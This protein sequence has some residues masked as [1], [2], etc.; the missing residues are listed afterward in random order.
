MKKISLI[1]FFASFFL[2]LFADGVQPSGSG[3]YSNPYQVE[4]L[5]NLLWISTNSIS[6]NKYIIQT[7]DIDASETAN[8]NNGSGFS[9]IGSAD[10]LSFPFTGNYNGQSK[11]INNLFI[12]RVLENT[13][14]FGFVYEGVL[15]NIELQNA[16][17][18]GF[19]FVGILAGYSNDSE[20][21]NIEVSGIINGNLEVGA[22]IGKSYG[23]TISDCSS[24]SSVMGGS[25]TGG[26]IGSNSNSEISNC[27]CYGNVT[28]SVYTGG[29]IGENSYSDIEYSYCT[30]NVDG[31]SPV[32]GFIA[33]NFHGD[34]MFCFC[35]G[36]VE[37]FDLT[38]GFIGVSQGAS[39]L[40]QCCSTGDVTGRGSVGGFAGNSTGG[41]SYTNLI[42]NCFSTGEVE[43]DIFVGGFAGIIN[44][45]DVYNCYCKGLVLE[46]EY[47]GGFVAFSPYSDIEN[48][49]WDI[50]TSGQTSSD[51]GTGKTT[52]EMLNVATYTS[53]P[54]IG[55]D[56]PWD[57]VGNP[58]DDTG[59]ED[60]WNIDP[61]END[62]YP[63][64]TSLPLVGIQE[65]E[66]NFSAN[67]PNLIGNYPNP[68][69]PTT[70]FSFSISE[71]S[72]VELV[73]YNIK[74]QRV[75]QLV[76]DRFEKGTHLVNWN[77]INESGDLIASGVYFYKLVV[78]GK[79]QSMKKCLMIK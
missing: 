75:M 50:E 67:K 9:P 3:T 29:F 52:S 41:S 55:L 65:E 20:V 79:H 26:L 15:Q 59:N 47:L 11:S 1:I 21:S 49:F 66:I 58:F 69:N 54:T 64:L 14:F 19:T 4:T 76:N 7:A 51:G 62:G 10:S 73:I 32:G 72:K 60:F 5:D 63:F 35:T 56:D 36:N 31:I 74:G 37:G 78:N 17:I 43:G 57:F 46:A 40:S 53:L 33:E 68:F 28:G 71:E 30:G 45:S 38:G 22:L 42:E 16:N 61:N 39:I 34:I 6:W 48:S 2:L 8:W 23:N 77:G 44:S 24:S 13:G 27:Y 12:D 70:T 25:S 18:I